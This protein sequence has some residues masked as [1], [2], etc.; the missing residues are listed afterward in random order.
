MTCE[1]CQAKSQL[2]LCNQHAAELRDMLEG[3]TGRTETD[4][5]TGE[6][7]P[8]PGW[9]SVLE[10]SVLGETRL[11]ESARRSTDQ[12]SPLPVHL[13]ASEL[14][15]DVRGTLGTWIRHLCETRGAKF[16]PTT[17]R[18]VGL[19]AVDVNF[20]GPLPVGQTRLPYAALVPGFVVNTLEMV[21][22]LTQNAAAIACDETAGEI[23]RDVREAVE[24]IERMVN[25]PMP[26]KYCGT[27]PT[28]VEDGDD[29]ETCRVGLY[30]EWDRKTKQHEREVTCWKCH[31][32]YDSKQ[33]ID[34]A[35]AETDG[36]LHTAQEVLELMAQI[37][38]PISD[39][40]WR[41]WRKTGAIQSRNE[42]GPEPKYFI[43]EV[44]YLRET[45]AKLRAS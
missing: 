6:T 9:L 3:L 38:E 37:G 1:V 32:V 35:L 22:W 12:T 25:R 44:R 30:A 13:K 15:D 40:T 42:L 24:S 39:R 7:H 20:I 28:P 45:M 36:W 31:A 4:M 16:T 17:P 21:D 14:L 18:P 8:G 10:D 11:G 27:C 33:L 23:F 26:P 41:H 43:G 29:D 34:D 5:L 2:F 19:R